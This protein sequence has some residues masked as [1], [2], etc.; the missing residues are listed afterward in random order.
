MSEFCSWGR[1]WARKLG[2]ECS[3]PPLPITCF[4]QVIKHLWM[5]AVEPMK[6]SSLWISCSETGLSS[7]W[8]GLFWMGCWMGGKNP[9]ILGHQAFLP[10][11]IQPREY[12]LIPIISLTILAFHLHL[13][14]HLFVKK[15]SQCNNFC[16]LRDLC[17][18]WITEFN[19]GQLSKS[20][21][22]FGMRY[23]ALYA[24][25][26]LFCSFS[27]YLSYFVLFCFYNKLLKIRIEINLFCRQ[28]IKPRWLWRKL[29]TLF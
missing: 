9:E 22:T 28:W 11:L 5:E 8:Q 24:R 21:H 4:A 10:Q 16:M 1:S 15:S 23:S 29:C 12:K 26:Q 13:P 27:I 3:C 19:V 18:L 14:S 2:E 17:E 25:F 7:C 6:V 20:G